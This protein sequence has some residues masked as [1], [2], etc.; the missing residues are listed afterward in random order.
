MTDKITPAERSALMAK[1]RSRDTK[2]EMMVRRMVFRMGY[3]Y[4]LHRRD[5]PGAPDLVFGGQRKVIF[6][7]GCFWH[8]HPGCRGARAPS[9]RTIYWGPKLAGNVKR[10][11]LNR[12]LL[13]RAGWSVL[14]VWECE[15]R[16]LSKLERRISRFLAHPVDWPQ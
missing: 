11:Q 14:I 4:R 13:R 16:S 8:Q 12:R 3:R 5:L 7:H 6:V 2:P 9:S 1:V 10:D 15:L